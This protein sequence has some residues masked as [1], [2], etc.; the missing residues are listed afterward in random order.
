MEQRHARILRLAFLLGAVTDAGALVPML[1]PRMA[2]ILWG[3][4]D[5]SG[6]RTRR[7][8]SRATSSPR[9]VLSVVEGW[10]RGDSPPPSKNAAGG[11]VGSLRWI[12]VGRTI[13]LL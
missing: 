12:A 3:F 7:M 4:E 2:E 10:P 9:P 6:P 5:V 13:S 1:S 11:G 8:N